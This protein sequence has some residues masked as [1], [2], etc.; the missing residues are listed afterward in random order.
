MHSND[1]LEDNFVVSET[2]HFLKKAANFIELPVFLRSN[3][4]NNS[5]KLNSSA[6]FFLK[7]DVCQ[8]CGLKYDRFTSKLIIQSKHVKR[9]RRKKYF[10]GTNK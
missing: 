7:S 3:L 6:N 1:K 9:Q 8:N 5:N 4:I 10:Y 2:K